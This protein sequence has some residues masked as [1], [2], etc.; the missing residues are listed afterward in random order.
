MPTSIESRARRIVDG[1]AK[2]LIPWILSAAYAYNQLETPLVSDAL[3]DEWARRLH[4]LWW[5]IEH[6]H[7][8]LITRGETTCMVLLTEDQYPS[9]VVGSTHRLL[10]TEGLAS[11]EIEPTQS[12]HPRGIARAKAA[13]RAV[14]GGT[15]AGPGTSKAERRAARRRLRRAKANGVG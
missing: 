2:M 12:Q 14:Q 4:R 13:R 10:V 11:Y 8:D 6:R 9:M 1:N 3:Y 15:T 7:R 5:R